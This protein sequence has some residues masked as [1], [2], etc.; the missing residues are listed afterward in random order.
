VFVSLVSLCY[1][2]MCQHIDHSQRMCL[3]VC[4]GVDTQNTQLSKELENHKKDKE[5]LLSAGSL[6]RGQLQ[7]I[8]TQYAALQDTHTQ[9]AKDMA[10]VTVKYKTSM[11]DVLDLQRKLHSAQVYMYASVPLAVSCCVNPTTIQQYLS[12]S[13]SVWQVKLFKVKPRAASKQVPTGSQSTMSSAPNNSAQSEPTQ[14]NRC[15]CVFAGIATWCVRVWERE[16]APLRAHT[17]NFVYVR[18]KL[19]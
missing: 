6:L 4:L 3:L 7:T 1:D 12:K 17:F 9:V 10:D 11:S 14:V 18:G 16:N 2:S 15:L 8:Q 19:T 13:V 5:T